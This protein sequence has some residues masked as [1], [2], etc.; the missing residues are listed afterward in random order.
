MEIFD[1]FEPS[2]YR[3]VSPYSG[4]QKLF[5]GDY[6]TS[7]SETPITG[8]SKYSLAIFSIPDIGKPFAEKNHAFHLEIRNFL[9][10]L[11]WGDQNIEILDMGFLKTGKN[12]NDLHAAIEYVIRFFVA[13]QI[14]PV[15]LGGKNS[16]SNL[17]FKAFAELQPQI[18]F[19]EIKP[20]IELALTENNYSYLEQILI[21]KNPVLSNFASIGYQTYLVSPFHLEFIKRLGFEAYCLGNLRSNITVS[22]PVLRDTDILSV[23]LSSV[24][25]ADFPAIN[26]P[27]PNGFTSDEICQLMRFAG[28]S[29]NLKA[30]GFFNFHPSFDVNSQSAMLLAQT[31]WHFLEGFS[32]RRHEN[33]LN[34][35]GQ[36]SRYLVESG[37]INEQIVFFKS[38][39]T[40]RW[41]LFLPAATSSHDEALISCSSED[42]T[43]S[44]NNEIPE[45]LWK[46]LQ[47]EQN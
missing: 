44:C 13:K 24:K 36:F 25:Q 26:Q 40:G 41:W 10:T 18:C 22:E 20:E 42:Y 19:S 30:I 4:K 5:L 1:Y 32:M 39:L 9:N 17:V 23:D 14:I 2:G 7:Y 15:I 37:Q 3:Y 46:F 47:R 31:I 12:K 8:F 16:Y 34:E 6:I 28:M 11:A 38:L 21:S 35:E 29:D 27:H 43:S 33:P 45:R